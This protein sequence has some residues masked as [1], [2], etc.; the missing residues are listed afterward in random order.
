MSQ[1]RE[2]FHLNQSESSFTILDVDLLIAKLQAL[3]VPYDGVSFFKGCKASMEIQN[4]I[5]IPI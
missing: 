4:D 5:V 1:K 2:A 3:P